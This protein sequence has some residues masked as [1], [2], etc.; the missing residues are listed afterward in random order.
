MVKL[1]VKKFF[2]KTQ[3]EGEVF[4]VTLSR[5]ELER[6]GFDCS[7]FGS[8]KT[9]DIYLQWFGDDFQIKYVFD[10]DP[11][12]TYTEKTSNV[13]RDVFGLIIDSYLERLGMGE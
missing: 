5:Q 9:A 2:K 12:Q 13:R 4:L 10:S 6:A 8:F 1:N 11:R 7:T 3:D